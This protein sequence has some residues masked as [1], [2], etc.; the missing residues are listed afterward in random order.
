MIV[1]NC[2]ENSDRYKIIYNIEIYI[3]YFYNIFMLMKAG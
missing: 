1:K 2:I 3:I